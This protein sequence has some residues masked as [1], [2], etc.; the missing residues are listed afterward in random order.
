M[1]AQNLTISIPPPEEGPICD[2]NCTYCISA[3]TGYIEPDVQTLIRNIGKARTLARAANVSNI[4]LT[5][6]GEPLL[7]F[8]TV[9]YILESF[10]EYPSE[11]QTNGLWLSRHHD[12]VDTLKRA[13]LDTV[14]ISVDH[15]NQMDDV[16]ELVRSIRRS[17]MTCRVC[18]NLTDKIPTDLSFRSI[19]D[20]IKSFGVHQL[21]I[22]NVMVPQVVNY[23]TKRAAN[24]VKWIQE[25]VDPRVYK[26]LYVDFEAMID[27]ERDLVRTLPHGAEVYALQGIDVSFSDYCIQ[28]NNNT[29]DI[30][31][32]I[33]LEDGHMYTS[34]DKVPASRLF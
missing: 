1:E 22:R 18:L 7:N 5:G 14:A 33:F 16:K 25:H 28:E 32:L 10:M 24:A 3:M 23:D 12:H 15:L 11:I 31:S 26:K 13:G 6:K 34:W 8:E 4:L 20:T 29:K 9:C 17:N 2:K 19:F 27:R 30:R 21:L